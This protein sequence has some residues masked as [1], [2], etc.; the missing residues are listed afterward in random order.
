MHDAWNSL[1]R[2]TQACRNRL[3]SALSRCDTFGRAPIFVYAS[4]WTGYPK[5]ASI[6]LAVFRRGHRGATKAM[7]RWR[8]ALQFR[9][10]GMTMIAPFLEDQPIFRSAD[11][12]ETVAFFR[13]RG[14]RLEVAPRHVR[15]LNVRV[16]CA[17]LQIGRASCRERVC[18]YV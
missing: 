3:Y 18:R 6:K 5:I 7:P 2:L 17:C 10:A 1:R 4:R 16:N 12:D 14:F 9:H 15:E 11:L 13:R 8:S